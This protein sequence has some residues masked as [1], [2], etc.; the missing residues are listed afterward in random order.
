MRRCATFHGGN[1]CQ[2]LFSCGN[3]LNC[4]RALQRRKKNT[5]ST[6]TPTPIHTRPPPPPT[7]HERASKHGSKAASKQSSKQ[8]SKQGS[9]QAG[10]PTHQIEGNLVDVCSQA[11]PD[12]KL[13][14]VRA[15]RHGDRGHHRG[16]PNA[17]FSR[18]IDG[19]DSRNVS[20]AG[21]CTREGVANDEREGGRGSGGHLQAQ[22]KMV[23]KSEQ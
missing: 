4:C 12:A 20:R 21:V 22:K 2:M 15:L 11:P 14:A 9:K 16:A 13:E 3:V 18:R 19:Q 7:Q 6:P 10:K 23:P 5:T 8:G 17:A 1:R